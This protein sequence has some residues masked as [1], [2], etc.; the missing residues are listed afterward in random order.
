MILYRGQ[1]VELNNINKGGAIRLFE[2]C[3]ADTVQE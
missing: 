3:L 1:A 2:A